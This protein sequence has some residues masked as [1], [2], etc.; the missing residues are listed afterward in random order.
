MKSVLL[1]AAIIMI[2]AASCA[3]RVSC[4]AYAIDKKAPIEQKQVEAERNM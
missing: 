4:P 2:S 1:F 3:P